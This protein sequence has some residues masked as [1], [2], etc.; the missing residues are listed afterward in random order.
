M[1]ESEQEIWKAIG[2]LL[3]IIIGGLVVLFLQDL[4]KR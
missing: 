1:D 4:T 2:Y 3:G